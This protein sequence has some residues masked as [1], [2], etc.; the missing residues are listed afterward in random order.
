VHT[1]LSGTDLVRSPMAKV[2]P[3]IFLGAW[4]GGERSLSED[5][6]LREFVFHLL[7]TTS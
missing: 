6:N 5:L 2:I 3:K 4:G 1:A 7:R